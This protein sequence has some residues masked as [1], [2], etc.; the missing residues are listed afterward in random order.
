MSKLDSNRM[1]SELTVN[2]LK[3]LI[4][5]VL[6]ETRQPDYFIDANGRLVFTTEGGYTAYLSKQFG[7]QPSEINACFLDANGCKAIWPDDQ[8]FI[9]RSGSLAGQIR[10]DGA[11]ATERRSNFEVQS[12][13][14]DPHEAA[15]HR[16]R[17]NS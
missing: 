13:T 7:R 16:L 1:V 10:H 11:L 5:K 9:A 14:S 12:S 15:L 4:R 8:S 17:G 6:S 3:D 2:E